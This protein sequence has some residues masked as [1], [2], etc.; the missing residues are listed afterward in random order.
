M[1][2]TLRHCYILDTD[3]KGS[4]C[5]WECCLSETL[6]NSALCDLT[7]V[8]YHLGQAIRQLQGPL[9]ICQITEASWGWGMSYG[10]HNSQSLFAN[11]LLS[12]STTTTKY[13]VL[14]HH[15]LGLYLPYKK[16]VLNH[17]PIKLSETPVTQVLDCSLCYLTTSGTR[18]ASLGPKGPLTASTPK[19]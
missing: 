18:T 9:Q 1:I 2:I 8:F 4:N 7:Y 3:R 12:S 15:A 10:W 14:V 17:M 5:W 13:P 6:C 11:M 16:H 19:P